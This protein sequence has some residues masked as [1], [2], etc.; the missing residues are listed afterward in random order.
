[1]AIELCSHTGGMSEGRKAGARRA[2]RAPG[3]CADTGSGCRNGA[4][5]QV[6]A[7]GG[8]ECSECSECRVCA[9]THIARQADCEQRA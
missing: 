8:L 5:E 4:V 2:A 1:M 3:P 7:S 9:E 6:G